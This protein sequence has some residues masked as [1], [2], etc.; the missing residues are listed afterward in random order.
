MLVKICSGCNISLPIDEFHKDKSRKDG[1]QTYCKFCKKKKDRNWY[2]SNKVKAR[3][4]RDTWKK[5]NR[6]KMREYSKKSME[7]YRSSEEGKAH[8][9]SWNEA[10]AD[11]IKKYQKRYRV[12]NAEKIS[13]THQKYVSENLAQIRESSRR[14]QRKRNAQKRKAVIGVIV[15]TKPQRLELQNFRCEICGCIEDEIPERKD[16][17]NKWEEDHI[18]PLSKG[19]SHTED[20][21]QILCWPCN[22]KKGDKL[23][24]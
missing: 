14:C 11:K 10:N 1:L 13:V 16:N 9:R 23:I 18:I 21:L 6:G 2:Q 12:N 5:D 24:E 3:K 7:K 22:R 20:N 15:L 19:G 8:I 17:R 4:S